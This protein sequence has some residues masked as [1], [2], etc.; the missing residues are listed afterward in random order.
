[1]GYLLEL[2]ENH[3][4]IFDY[5]KVKAEILTSYAV[6]TRYPGADEISFEEAREAFDTAE[7]IYKF[8]INLLKV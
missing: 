2:C 8:V 3:G 1:M 6:E 5:I 4:F 7:I